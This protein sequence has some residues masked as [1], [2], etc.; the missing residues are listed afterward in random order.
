MVGRKKGET[1]KGST[2]E[3]KLDVK[4]SMLKDGYTGKG[5]YIFPNGDKPLE[6]LRTVIDTERVF[7]WTNGLDIKEILLRIKWR[8][9]YCFTRWG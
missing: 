8:K 5:T 3:N 7:T 4:L 9:R 6:V 2:L 1:N